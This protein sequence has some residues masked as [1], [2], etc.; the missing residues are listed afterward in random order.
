M[1]GEAAKNDA[2]YDLCRARIS[3]TGQTTMAALY[4]AELWR[5][6]APNA[7]DP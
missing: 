2:S 1:Q 6:V 5:Y 7:F 3:V 4:C